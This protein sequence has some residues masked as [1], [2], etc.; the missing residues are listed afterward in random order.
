MYGLIL[1]DF[2]GTVIDNSEGIYNCINYAL[3][4]MD[5]PL[6]PEEILRRFVGP[7][8]FDSYMENCEP[9]PE[10]AELFMQL[11]RERYAPT[12]HT[13][14]RMYDGMR[15]LLVKLNADGYRVAVCS[16]KPL[17]FVK[18]I[19]RNLD[20]YDLFSYYSCPGFSSV[21]S[22]K[23]ELIGLA[24]A[25]FD[26]PPE[27]VLMIGDRRFDIEAAKEAGTASLGVRYGFAEEGELERAGADF[28]A[29][30]VEDIYTLIAGERNK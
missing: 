29:D 20:M 17:D 30:T 23:S 18:K 5:M 12:G 21:T 3:G 11:Y 13:E 26:V 27:K 10:R 6:L 22:S 8:L 15:E 9:V 4:K 24:A 14:C 28:I 19:A 1:F 16:S 25:Y 2:D 7:S